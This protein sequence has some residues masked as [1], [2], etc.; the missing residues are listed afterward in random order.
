MPSYTA[1]DHV[2]RLGR[3]LKLN[4]T[5]WPE[6]VNRCK[7][8]GRETG[9]II[10]RQVMDEMRKLRFEAEGG[11]VYR[12]PNEWEPVLARMF[13]WA[14]PE[15]AAYVTIQRCRFDNVVSESLLD[16]WELR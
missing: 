3:F 7:A 13:R 15:M 5:F 12:L 8:H 10:V 11:E 1:Q 2:M 9:Y 4:P 14:V 16:D 6:F